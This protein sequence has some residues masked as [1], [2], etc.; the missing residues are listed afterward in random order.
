M[1]YCDAAV[2]AAGGAVIMYSAVPEVHP[3]TSLA[4][5]HKGQKYGAQMMF[6]WRQMNSK[7][8]WGWQTSRQETLHQDLHSLFYICVFPAVFD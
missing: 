5:D 1:F 7:T 2:W 8:V 6:K 4:L 3:A